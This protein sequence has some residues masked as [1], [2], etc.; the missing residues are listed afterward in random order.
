MNGRMETI[1]SPAMG[2]HVY[3]WCFGHW[4]APLIVF[5]TAAGF[6]HEWPKQSMVQSL[7]P[8]IDNGKIKLYCTESNISETWTSKDHSLG[9]IIDRHKAF[10]S[11]I[12]G[13]LVPAIYMDCRS[14]SIPI[15]L[16]GASMG[17]YFAVNFALKYPHLF[18][19]SLCMSGRYDITHFTQGRSNTDVY[20][21]NPVAYVANLNG[22][23]LEQIQRHTFFSLVCG[24]GPYEDG[25][26]EDTHALADLFV[27]KTIPHYRDIWGH[28]V[29]HGWSW[30]R[31]QVIHHLGYRYG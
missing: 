19:Y 22:A 16:A 23:S 21:N 9:H 24:Q 12:V 1:Y 6:A 2:R 26:I 25:C 27:Q 15:G 3:V 28:D 30:W 14:P 7:A 10:E 20:F 18:N 4:G 31:R 5:P 29:E 8:L 11:F 17:A 13:D